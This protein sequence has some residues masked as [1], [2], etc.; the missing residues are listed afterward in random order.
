MGAD[1]VTAGLT[2]VSLISGM[3]SQRKAASTAKSSTDM[4]KQLVQRQVA[5]YDKMMGAVEAA[6]KGG[7]FD[8]E[9]QIAQLEKDTAKYESQDAGNVAG[10]AARAGYL[11]GDTPVQ[12]NLA[13]VKLSYRDYLDRMRTSLRSNA[14]MQKLSAYGSVNPSQL[15]SGISTYGQIGQNALAGAPGV[16]GLLGA[17]Q[18]W[19]AKIGMKKNPAGPTPG[20][21]SSIYDYL[22]GMRQD[23]Y[24][25]Y[26]WPSF[27][28]G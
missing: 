22:P 9:T 10:A 14:I 27:A 28:N 6:D 25:G 2:A 17:V 5:L 18:P 24:G 26:L 19:L 13:R 15:N 21:S 8:P 7:A 3:E 1:P 12:T 16:G 11:P 4:Q 20:A 23:Q